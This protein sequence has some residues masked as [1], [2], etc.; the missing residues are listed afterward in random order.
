MLAALLGHERV[1][2]A[3]VENAEINVNAISY[4]NELSALM[5]AAA[6]VA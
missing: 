5:I 1:V 3:L 4:R 2:A 6:K